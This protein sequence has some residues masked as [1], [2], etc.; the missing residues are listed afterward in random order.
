MNMVVGGAWNRYDGDHFGQIIWAQVATVPNHYRYYFNNGD[1]RDFN[2]F[3]KTN[4]QFSARLNGFADL[5]YRRVTYVTAG[6]E[7]KQNE[8]A[9]DAGYNFFNPKAGLTYTLSENQSVYASYSVGNREPVRDD[10]VDNPGSSPKPE[11]TV[12]PGGRLQKI[13]RPVY[14]GRQYLLDGLQK[15]TCTHRR[16]QRRGC[17]GSHQRAR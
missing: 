6:V 1:K 16:A 11:S 5:Q 4:F 12:Q 8:F 9:I 15:S 13:N 3:A 7:N 17:F 10:F 14:A 2:M